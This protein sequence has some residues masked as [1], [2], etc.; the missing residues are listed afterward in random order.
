MM[1][2]KDSTADAQTRRDQKKQKP[3]PVGSL[4]IG[5]ARVVSLPQR[6]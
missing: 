6:V 4:L 2:V 5:G 1:N 3:Q